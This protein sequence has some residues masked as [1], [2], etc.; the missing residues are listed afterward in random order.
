[1]TNESIEATPRSVRDTLWKAYKETT[2]FDTKLFNA[3]FAAL[4]MLEK[5]EARLAALESRESNLHVRLAAL[6]AVQSAP[7]PKVLYEGKPVLFP[8]KDNIQ[9]AI[10]AIED[11]RRQYLEVLRLDTCRTIQPGTNII[12]RLAD[13]QRY[14]EELEKSVSLRRIRRGG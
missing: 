6:E 4:T 8:A 9:L 2:D 12:N 14:L 11:I 1:M 5:M 3:L 13:A 7:A 10:E